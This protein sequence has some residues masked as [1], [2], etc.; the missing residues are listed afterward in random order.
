MFD[1][2]RPERPIYLNPAQR[3]G[4]EMQVFDP[5]RCPGL[6]LDCTFGAFL[7]ALFER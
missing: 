6:Q 1:F 3:A 5:G 7:N 2:V 4:L